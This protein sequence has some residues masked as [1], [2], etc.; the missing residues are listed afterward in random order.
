MPLN[1]NRQPSHLRPLRVERGERD[2]FPL[3]APGMRDHPFRSPAVR[4]QVMGTAPGPDAEVDQQDHGNTRRNPLPQPGEVQVRDL[5]RKSPPS[6]GPGQ[7]GDERPL[8]TLRPGLPDDFPRVDILPQE[9]ENHRE[10][11]G[12]AGIVFLGKERDPRDDREERGRRLRR[13]DGFRAFPRAR[14]TRA[15]SQREEDAARQQ[16]RGQEKRIFPHRGSFH[17]FAVTSLGSTATSPRWITRE[18]RPSSRASNSFPRRSNRHPDR[19][20]IPSLSPAANRSSSS[21]FVSTAGATRCIRDR[22]RTSA[23]RSA[24]TEE[25]SPLPRGREG[26]ASGSRSSGKARAS[27]TI[28]RTTVDD[29]P[30]LFHSSPRTRRSASSF[31]G[32]LRAIARALSSASTRRRGTSR[33]LASPSR[34]AIRARSTAT[35]RRSR[36]VHPLTRRYSFHGSVS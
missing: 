4:H 36:A 14:S 8:Q 17:R 10:G 27:R 5:R 28:S 29:P 7:V 30:P 20:G 3:F 31:A 33:R 1:D 16:G 12:A 32:L 18:S 25:R 34:H 19:T 15:S 24:T 23:P 13:W 26:G 21:L 9:L 35:R 11:G 2:H 6:G 22:D